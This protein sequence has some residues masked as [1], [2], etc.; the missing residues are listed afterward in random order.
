MRTRECGWLAALSLASLSGCALDAD[1]LVLLPGLSFGLGGLLLAVA[2]LALLVASR[3]QAGM[4]RRMR[5]FSDGVGVVLWKMDPAS[6]RYLQ[7]SRRAEALLGYPCEAWL[8]EDFW[9][10]HLHPEDRE[11]ACNLRATQLALG[12]NHEIEYRMV[13]AG[14]HEV[15][16]RDTAS[17]LRDQRGCITGLA[18]VLIDVSAHR[19]LVQ[20]LDESESRFRK[21]MEQIP[22]IAVQG[23]DSER[24]VVFWNSASERVYGWSQQEALGKRLEDLIIPD[25]MREDVIE[26]HRRWLEYGEAIPAGELALRTKGGATVPV[27][28]CHVLT[29]NAH[30]TAEM[31][32][33][34]VEMED[35]KR[36]EAAWR[37]SERRFQLMFAKA[38]V[39]LA[40]R[41]LDGRLTQVNPKICSILGYPEDQLL[42]LDLA[43]LTYPDDLPAELEAI[44]ACLDGRQSSYSLEKR[45]VRHDGS[46]VW[47]QVTS[48]LIRDESGGATQFMTVVEDISQRKDREAQI[49]WLAHHDS[50]TDLPNRALLRDRLE[51]SIARA[52][53]R[54]RRAA[55]LVLDLDRFKTINDSLGHAVGDQLLQQVA[56]RLRNAV[57]ET[58]TVSRQGGDE[59]L[60][61]LGEISD[62]EDIARIVQKIL[63][64][65]ELPFELA[66]QSLSSSVSIGISVFPDDGADS[67]TL[68]KNADSAMYCAKEG[69][70]NTFRFYAEAMNESALERLKMESALRLAIE[71]D[72]LTL[73]YQPQVELAGRSLLGVEALL[74]WNSA[75]LGSV[76]PGRFIPVAEDSGLIVAIGQWVLAQACEQVR[77]WRKEGVGDICIAVN[78]SA[79]QF[80]RSD[81][82][83]TVRDAIEGSAIPAHLIELE[84]TESLLMQNAEDVLRTMRELK[85][86]G[87]RLSIDDFGTGYSSLSYLK[88]FPVDRLKVDRSFVKDAAENPDDAAIVRAIIQLGK[89][90]KLDVIAEGAETAAQIDFLTAEGCHSVQ[91]YYFARPQPEREIRALLTLAAIPPAT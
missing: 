13:D 90:L 86:L 76:P 38:E 59:F 15:A 87:V 9:R 32:C 68:L 6:G 80:R 30:G 58:D 20:A 85:A 70:R 81:I 89:S 27:F 5:D 11:F 26:L 8:A 55:L 53:R 77:R 75:T 10:E 64:R 62:L 14:G 60:I 82:V 23:Y 35:V 42:C 66:G 2:G 40:L 19:A 31:Y 47:A 46:T 72:E 37:E 43:A 51:R 65:M 16:V 1:W 88:R 12:L 73:H 67:D 7:V 91:G 4:I 78:L 69:G 54:E 56:L 34:D 50:L 22:N 45:Y 61:V 83:A 24:R 49:A 29:R 28:S 17:V 71:R 39:G 74:R 44:A 52:Q 57:R 3:R 79:L 63:E 41:T 21:V 84:L 36:T 48:S 25:A 33:L 18:G